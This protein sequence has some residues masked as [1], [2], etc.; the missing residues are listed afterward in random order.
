[1][2]IRD[3]DEGVRILER[4]FT[5]LWDNLLTGSGN[6]WDTIKDGFSAMLSSMIHEAT[7]RKIMLNVQQGLAGTNPNVPG[8]GINWAQLG[9][10]LVLFASIIAG[11]ELGG[12]G[13][14]A[15]TGATIG[16]LAGQ[17][18][19]PIPVLGAAIGAVLGLYAIFA[20]VV[21]L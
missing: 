11:S 1:M 9:G 10:D 2:C 7:T 12:G 17:F 5:A 4:T 19:I 8:G 16:A 3:R 20:I 13:T 18:L 21:N 6:V 15:K 14:G